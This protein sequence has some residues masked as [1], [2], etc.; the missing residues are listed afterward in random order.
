MT[1][2][3]HDPTDAAIEAQRWLVDGGRRWRRMDPSL[4][5]DVVEALTSH[6]GRGRSAVRTANRDGDADAIAAARARVNLAKHGL[7][8]RGTYWWDAPEGERLERARDALRKLDA[9]D[10]G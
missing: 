8:E 3:E 10:E 6:L 5:A 2:P 1:E 4:P 7:G 9:L